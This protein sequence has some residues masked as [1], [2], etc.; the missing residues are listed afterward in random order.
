MGDTLCPRCRRPEATPDDYRQAS[1]TGTSREGLCWGVDGGYECD[2]ARDAFYAALEAEVVALRSK[3]A[4]LR[5]ALELVSCGAYDSAE[6][7]LRRAVWPEGA[8]A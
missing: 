6:A 8:D 5:D 4:L 2:D 3:V 7:V 1:D